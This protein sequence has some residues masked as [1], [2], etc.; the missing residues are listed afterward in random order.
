MAKCPARQLLR[1]RF[2]GATRRACASL[3]IQ[4][5]RSRVIL[6]ALRFCIEAN[7]SFFI[8]RSFQTT[9]CRNCIRGHGQSKQKDCLI[10][11]KEL[12]VVFEN[13]E[14][15]L[16]YLC[17]GRVSVFYVN[18]SVCE[19]TVTKRVVDADDVS[20]RQ[21]VTLAQRLPAVLSVQE[22]VSEP[23][24]QFGVFSQ[25]ADGSYAEL[26]RLT[27]PHHQR[28]GVVKPERLRHGHAKFCKRIADLVE[29]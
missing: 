4:V 2:T 5:R 21:R 9:Q 22:F 28:V 14:I 10:L 11:W 7:H 18:R 24:L 25:V 1:K 27:A 16:F 12:K 23:D 29:R 8:Q 19:R 6:C 13:D 17:I 3:K 26:L 15:V 20:L